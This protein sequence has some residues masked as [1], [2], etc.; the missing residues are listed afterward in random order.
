MRREKKPRFW[1]AAALM[2]A[3]C[4]PSLSSSG[5]TGLD[6]NDVSVLFPMPETLDQR[7]QL[8]GADSRLGDGTELWSDVTFRSLLEVA[9]GQQL[10]LS[11]GPTA[12]SF[13]AEVRDRSAWRVV[14][15]RFDP[16]ATLGE[17]PTASN[18]VQI[19][20][21]LQPLTQPSAFQRTI[22]ADFA[23]HLIYVFPPDSAARL[24]GE[25]LAIKKVMTTGKPLGIHPAMVGEGLGGETATAMKEFLA[26]NLSGKRL[27]LI[28]MM[29]LAPEPEPW[30][31]VAGSVKDDGTVAV[32]PQRF[33]SAI[34]G[35][36]ALN[37]RTGGS[38]EP[39][40]DRTSTARLMATALRDLDAEGASAI[41]IV[42]NPDKSRLL[43]LSQES[44]RH[45][46]CVSCHT[47]T[48]ALVRLTEK[49]ARSSALA[50][51]LENESRFVTPAGVT[52]FLDPA[53]IRDF[54]VIAHGLPWSVRNFGYFEGKP[55]IT[56]RA[57][58]ETALV[59][60]RSN[61]ILEREDPFN[62]TCNEK[63]I[64]TC[65]LGFG[66]TCVEAGCEE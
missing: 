22:D 5:L 4:T 50:L 49:G 13:P 52:G 64:W 31:F 2:F 62:R 65:V 30:V 18:Q 16:E 25:L 3:A 46:D 26:R 57:A 37:F 39:Q 14:G 55:A 9:A 41:A 1:L 29:G 8:M 34:H 21:I 40:F 17:G 38:V 48:S 42:G 27:R 32:A 44:E 45:R 47:E 53:V 11:S 19:R 36:Q 66:S 35:A 56:M 60:K 43:P 61:E 54:T 20:L 24:A 33:G 59:A 12:I 58:N 51:F 6:V 28:A 15:F 7:G 23:T 63:K 10:A